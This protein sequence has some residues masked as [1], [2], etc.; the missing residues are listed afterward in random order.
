MFNTMN[1]TKAAGA[2]IGATLFLLLGNWAANAI[3]SIGGAG[4]GDEVAQ[5]EA[6]AEAAPAAEPAAE[7][8]AETAAAE[9]A[10]TEAPAAEAAA[11]E[12]DAAEPEAAAAETAA[13]EP[14]AA[15]APAAEAAAVAVAGDPAAGEKVFGKCKACH[16]IDG[17]N[18]TGPH[19]DGVVGRAVGSVA[20]FKYS[21]AMKAFGGEWTPE[22]LD[23]YLTQPKEYIPGNKMSFAGLRKPEDRANVIAYLTG[24]G[25]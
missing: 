18:I 12:P 9:P 15:E 11:A 7:T 21:D 13:A 1:L 24:L 8:A 6:P 25:G 14:A 23:A 4:H 17:K 16:K 2:V 19:L 5:A 3:Y 10:E 22:R 20:E